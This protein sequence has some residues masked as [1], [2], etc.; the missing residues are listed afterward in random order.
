MKNPN[1]P[2]QKPLKWAPVDESKKNKYSAD[3]WFELGLGRQ[4]GLGK[5]D[6]ESPVTIGMLKGKSSAISVSFI[7][8]ALPVALEGKWQ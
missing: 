7:P 2:Q 1:S 5:Q 4:Q 6:Y 3:A 8:Q